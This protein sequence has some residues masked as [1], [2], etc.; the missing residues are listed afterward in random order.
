[1]KKEIM[2]VRL[3]CLFIG[4]LLIVAGVEFTQ[5]GLGTGQILDRFST[6]WFTALVLYML[7]A[8]FMELICVWGVIRPQNLL[9]ECL[10]PLEQRLNALGLRRWL[11][12]VVVMITLSI[13][14]LGPWGWRFSAFAFRGL[15]LLV[16][17]LIAGLA[18]PD[19]V[20]SR[21]ERWT[22][23]VLLT[24][25]LFIVAKHLLQVTGYPFKLTWSEGNRL[26]DYSLYF[27]RDRY[28]IHEEFAY[29]SY[30]T[31]GRHG[32]WGLPF[33]IPN[34]TIQFLRFWDAVLWI[35]PFLLLGVVLFQR[36]DILVQRTTQL[37]LILWVFLFLSQGPI[38]APLVLSA[39]LLVWGYDRQRPWRSLLVTM[40]ACLYAGISRWTWMFAPALWAALWGLLERDS[41]PTLWRRLSWPVALGFAGIVGAIGSQVLL[42]IAFPRPQPIYTTAFNQSMLWNRLLPN[43]TNPI[44]VL[45]GLIIA[46][47]P[48]LGLVGWAIW[49]KRLQFDR[50]HLL[51]L[52]SVLVAFLSVGLIASVKIGGGSNL[53]NLDMFLVALVLV[54][55]VITRV[56]KWG[57]GIP[58]G[59]LPAPAHVM[60]FLVVIVPSLASINSGGPLQLPSN[61]VTQSAIQRIRNTIE[62]EAKDGEVLF[63]DQRQLLTFGYVQDVPL[64]ME[65][66]LKELTNR[67]MI[68]DEVL[69]MDFY[70]DLAETR[71]SLIVTA[72]MPI[73]WSGRG[74]PFGEEDDA[75]LRFIYLPIQ[76]K[77]RP[78]AHLEEV[79]IWLMVPK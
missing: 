51:G 49:R 8:I 13:V 28:V 6:K 71:F 24:G 64:V 1:M 53:H 69:F 36:R 56:T 3:G 5:Q 50:V 79:G 54:I 47:G 57:S 33:L 55:G 25:S 23:S 75:Q 59:Q 22:I 14:L 74:H 78:L 9:S 21:L 48:L 58:S 35:L 61:D 60:L 73:E 20:G 30:L 11:F 26:W 12:S 43:A 40:T 45:P 46:T 2:V 41:N 7:G 42:N 52:G 76:K 16:I 38:Y 70:R 29:P 31:P 68:G 19:S 32:L 66:E 17:S 67:A 77:Y 15:L 10:N 4:I 65:Y 72:H 63:L 62:Q 27:G 37:G 44:G 34:V 18:L 39:V